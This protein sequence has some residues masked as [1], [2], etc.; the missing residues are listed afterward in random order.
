MKKKLQYLT[1]EAEELELRMNTPLA[2]SPDFAGD[3][4]KGTDDVTWSG[5]TDTT[6]GT[7]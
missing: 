1:P 4:D 7:L 6:W 3:F 2:S 5:E